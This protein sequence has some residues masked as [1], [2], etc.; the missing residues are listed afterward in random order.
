M[1]GEN[2]SLCHPLASVFNAADA[3]LWRKSR[4]NTNCKQPLGCLQCL[5]RRTGSCSALRG[6]IGAGHLPLW[7]GRRFPATA[8]LRNATPSP[9]LPRAS[10]GEGA[11]RQTTAGFRLPLRG[12]GRCAEDISR[13]PAN[14]KEGCRSDFGGQFGFAERFD[15]PDALGV[16]TDGSIG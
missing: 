16:V 1:Q 9:T 12:L 4:R 15:V 6:R 2:T 10:A 5:F 11:Q 7:Y 14:K 13:R 3:V 8:F